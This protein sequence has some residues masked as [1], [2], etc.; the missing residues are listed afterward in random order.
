MTLRKLRNWFFSL[1][2]LLLI[3][4]ATLS[5]LVET[6]T[7]SRWVVNR[8]AGLADVSLGAVTGNLRTGLDIASVD[9]Q[10]GELVFHAEQVSFRWR[11]IDLFYSALMIDSLSARQLS[12]QLPVAAETPP[13]ATPFSTWPSLRLPVRVQLRNLDLHGIRYRQGDQE[14][15]WERLSGDLGLGTFNLRY[16]DL[17][18]IHRDY[19]LR[20][21]G[22]TGLDYPYNSD[23]ELHWQWQQPTA[24]DG[25]DGLLYRGQSQL[26]GSLLQLQVD[27]AMDS[28]VQAKA[29][30]SGPLVNDK[31]ELNLEPPLAL[32]LEW[33]A[34]T[35]PAAWWMADKTA[36]VTQG[37]LKAEGNWQA[38]RATLEGAIQLPDAPTLSLDTQVDGNLDGLQI[39]HLNIRELSERL[40][41]I[42]ASSA[43]SAS[44]S[45]TPEV[46]T[47]AAPASAAVASAPAEATEPSPNKAARLAIQGRVNWLPVLE[48]QL[49]VEATAFNLAGIV[50]NWPSH[51]NAG[52]TTSGS[53]KESQWQAALRDLRI[54]GELR[55]VNVQGSGSVAL[56]GSTLRS[57]ALE[58]IV[59]ANQMQLKGVVG[60]DI[61]LNWNINAPLL[62]QIDESLS[63][64]VISKGELRGDRTRP[65]IGIT[66]SANQFRWGG[67]ALEKLELSLS[68]QAPQAEP[69][70]GPALES[71]SPVQHA[72]SAASPLANPVN[73]LTGELLQENYQ[74][75]FVANRVQLAQQYFSSITLKGEGS[76]AKHQVQA[77]VRSPSLGRADIGV[78]G[79][80]DDYAWQGSL[81]QLAIKLT[82]VPRWWLTSSKPIRISGSG[83][84]LGEQ[85]LTTRTNLTAAVERDT[86]VEREQLRGE[87]QPNQSPALGNRYDWLVSKPSLPASNIEKYNLPRLCIQGDW[88]SSTGAMLDAQLDAVPLR[89]FLSLFK[90]E[91]YFAGVMDGSLTLTSPDLSLMGTR[92]SLNV[93]TRNAELRYQY[94]G[95]VT[96]MYPWHDFALR[97]QLQN[98]QLTAT[99]GLEWVGYGRMDLDTQ[100]DLQKQ[101][102]NRA[103]LQIGFHNIAPLE[104]LLPFTNDVKGELTADLTAGG[105]FSAPYLL[106]DI[107]LRNGSANMTRLGLDLQGIEL[108]VNSTRAGTISL[109][110]QMQSGDG[111]M[112]VV[113]DLNGFG[114]PHWRAQAFINGTDFRVVSLPQLKANLSPNI[115]VVADASAMHLTGDAEI[116]WARANIKSLPPSAT[117]VSSDVVIVDEKYL[118]AQAAS[119]FDVY[120]NLN[121]SLGKD[122]SFKGFGLSS[123]LTGRL[124]L[125]KE[126]HRPFFTNGYVSVSEGSYKAYGQT[127]TIE[128]GRLAFQGPYDDPGLDIRA[129]RQIRDSDSTKVGLDI[130]GTLQRPK[131]KVFSSPSR[132]DSEAMMMLLTGK[133]I[134]DASDADASLL[135]SA[136]SGLGMDSGGSITAEINRF[137]RVDQLEVKSDDGIDQSQLWVG[138][139]LTPKLLVRYV[140]GIF[141]Q[142]FSF[143]I[144]YQLTDNFRIEAESGE[145]KSVDV[146]YK[147][148]R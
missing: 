129:T 128:R 24:E 35:L 50:D 71:D 13:D 147:I 57:D 91:V 98:A 83:V 40:Q 19:Q 106:G 101:A 4:L 37:L 20:L 143:G 93:T 134:K 62:Q 48:W 77:I 92:A 122:V 51:L 9:Y 125:L 118:Q 39:H 58:L 124:N 54:E 52:F 38:Y 80:Y 32:T 26:Q 84:V 59:G 44:A 72:A 109:M 78:Q 53:L 31:R 15:V 103:R 85:C 45:S 138:K 46:E 23:A 142:A 25:S 141:D 136:M 94:E 127:L 3:L 1:V 14:L 132:S 108:N 96:D 114:S 8:L 97:A 86:A 63:G 41:A 135:L 18:L 137:F 95:G 10:Q 6:Q 111:R 65:R 55:G 105:T 27:N 68:P 89:Q 61:N 42:A 5:A 116:P 28:P 21:S 148:E 33:P 145:T 117:Q 110:S 36:P 47:A 67:N 113:G 90:T 144:E 81:N 12:L 7:G 99:T 146:V 120:S 140:V 130:D 29:L 131:A 100:L 43:S 123:K 11:P 139:Y 70:V 75:S 133:P 74:L 17:S 126:A 30:V 34:Q 115:K 76:V 60:D 119:P 64:S 22:R 104:T 66:A 79:E 112:T 49:G 73:L 16:R 102:I 87:W 69:L 2:A 107:H 88:A 56:D 82:K 121:L